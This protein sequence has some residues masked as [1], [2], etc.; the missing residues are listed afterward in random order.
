MTNVVIPESTYHELLEAR[1][2]CGRLQLAYDSLMDR[3]LIV[4]DQ[5]ETADN[6][7]KEAVQ[8]DMAALRAENARLKRELLAVRDFL[9]GF[10]DRCD[11]FF[12]KSPSGPPPK[13][14]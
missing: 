13:M 2:A 4:R 6:R 11:V 7:A 1:A 14:I 12:P 5:R 10:V 3:L 8:A 9:G